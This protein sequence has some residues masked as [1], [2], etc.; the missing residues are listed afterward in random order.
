MH[1][2]SDPWEMLRVVPAQTTRLENGL[3][4]MRVVAGLVVLRIAASKSSVGW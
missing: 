1:Q 4:R 2:C 3:P